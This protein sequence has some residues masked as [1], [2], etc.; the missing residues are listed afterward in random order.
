MRKITRITIRLSSIILISAGLFACDKTSSEQPKTLDTLEQ[1]ASYS[2]GVDV[3]KGLKK[4]GIKLDI[5]ALNRGIADSYN[6]SSLALTDEE[7]LSAKTTFQPF[8]CLM[9]C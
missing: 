1:K 9:P 4:Q 7:R 2:F 8:C 6:D 5:D 3:A